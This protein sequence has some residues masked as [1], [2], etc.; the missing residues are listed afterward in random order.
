M[1]KPSAH[2]GCN[3]FR[4]TTAAVRGRWL[5]TPLSRRQVIAGGLGATLSVYAARA[6]PFARMLEAA[7]AQA[8]TAPNA[9]VLVSVF[10]PGGCDLLNTFVPLGQY[11]AYA[12]ARKDIKV[13][14]PPALGST[15]LGVNPALTKGTGGGIAGL[16]EAGKIGLLPGIDYANPG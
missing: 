2:R 5:D 13:V 7:E 15:G 10:L 3:D 8:A 12:D 1:P 16:Y 6:M 4:Q 11:G 9:P 14:A